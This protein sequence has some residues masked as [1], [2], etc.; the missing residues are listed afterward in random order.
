MVRLL[1]DGKGDPSI[2]NTHG[3]TPLQFARRKQ[4]TLLLPL[5]TA[6][7]PHLAS[8]SHAPLT[9]RAPLTIAESAADGS[10][11]ILQPAASPVAPL[12][13]V[14]PAADGSPSSPQPAASSLA[15]LIVEVSLPSGGKQRIRRDTPMLIRAQ[16]A[17]VAHKLQQLPDSPDETGSRDDRKAYKE[18]KQRIQITNQ[19]ICARAEKRLGLVS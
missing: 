7:I 9:M 16:R 12:T 1:L 3:E 11:S 19:Q 5:L 4:V 14:E 10:P 6:S 15:L 2:Q 18:A 17:G 8:L 13:M